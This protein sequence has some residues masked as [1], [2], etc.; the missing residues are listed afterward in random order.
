MESTYVYRNS[1]GVKRTSIV[2]SEKPWQVKVFTEVEMD[3][4][5]ESIKMAREEGHAPGSANRLVARVPMTVVEQSIHEQ[6]DD[7]DWKKWLNDPDNAAF[8][9]WRGRV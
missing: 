3:G 9:V 7:D 8:R 6:W 2:D 4:V 5:I 1:D